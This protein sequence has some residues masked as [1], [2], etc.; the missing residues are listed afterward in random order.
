MY[1]FGRCLKL[2]IVLTSFKP[3]TNPIR[4]SVKVG[5]WAWGEVI[6]KYSG[7]K[8]IPGDPGEKKRKAW[9]MPSRELGKR[10]GRSSVLKVMCMCACVH[11]FTSRRFAEARWNRAEKWVVYLAFQIQREIRHS[12]TLGKSQPSGRPQKR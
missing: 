12:L 10:R 5:N 11:S 7:L 6:G 8:I 4:P 3:H 2:T 1:S 9:M